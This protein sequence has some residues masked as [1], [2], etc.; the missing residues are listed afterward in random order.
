MKHIISYKIQTAIT[1][2]CVPDIISVPKNTMSLCPETGNET[3]FLWSWPI[4]YHIGW[5][6]GFNWVAS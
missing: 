5:K 3:P 1:S 6:S 4:H 2:F